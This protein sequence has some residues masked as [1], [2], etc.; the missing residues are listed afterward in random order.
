MWTAVSCSFRRLRMESTADTI[1][2]GFGGA[3]SPADPAESEPLS[4]PSSTSQAEDIPDTGSVS[5]L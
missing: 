2:S 3:G 4:S 5:M 1:V